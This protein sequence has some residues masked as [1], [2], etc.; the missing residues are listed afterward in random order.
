MYDDQ[1]YQVDQDLIFAACTFP[2]I[3]TA[4]AALT[5]KSSVVSKINFYKAIKLN[6]VKA[7]VKV[8]AGLTGGALSSVVPLWIRLTDGTTEYARIV[9]SATGTAGDVLDGTVKTANVP[10]STQLYWKFVQTGTGGGTVG[11]LTCGSYDIHIA[12]QERWS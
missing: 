12:Y 7:V 5:T 3:T 8:K 11:T 6:Q 4:T 10:K 2:L 9:V 1:Q